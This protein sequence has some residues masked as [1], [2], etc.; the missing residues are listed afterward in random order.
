AKMYFNPLPPWGGRQQNCTAAVLC[1]AADYTILTMQL[2]FFRSQAA[3]RAIFAL[4]S[5]TMQVRM[6]R[7]FMFACGSH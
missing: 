2:G 7:V 4:F 5:A 6:S 1:A 3:K